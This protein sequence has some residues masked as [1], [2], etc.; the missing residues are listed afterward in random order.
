MTRASGECDSQPRVNALHS[1]KLNCQLLCVLQGKTYKANKEKKRAEKEKVST[2]HRNHLMHELNLILYSETADRVW[3]TVTAGA[4]KVSAEMGTL[5][6][7][8]RTP[9][10]PNYALD[11]YDIVKP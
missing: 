7:L 4:G 11:A 3:S 1:Q 10:A 5:R 2:R 9:S 6:L 8:K